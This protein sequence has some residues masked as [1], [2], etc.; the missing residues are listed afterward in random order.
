MLHPEYPAGSAAA[1][2]VDDDEDIATV[3]SI[4]GRRWTVDFRDEGR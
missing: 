1:T 3:C 4:F 2:K